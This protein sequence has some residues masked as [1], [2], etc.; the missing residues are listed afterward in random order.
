MNNFKQINQFAT[1]IYQKPNKN[2]Y[3]DEYMHLTNYAINKKNK[4]Y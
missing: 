2:N 4:K 3:D 1:E